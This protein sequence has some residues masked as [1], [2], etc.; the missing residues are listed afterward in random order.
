MAELTKEN[1]VQLLGSVEEFSAEQIKEQLAIRDKAAAALLTKF[2][3]A[4]GIEV[5]GAVRR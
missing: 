5:K 3:K 2:R 1:L 4:Q